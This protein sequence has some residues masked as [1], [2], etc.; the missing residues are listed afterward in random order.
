MERRITIRLLLAVI[1]FLLLFALILPATRPPKARAQR[2]SGVNSV[3][4]VTL[5]LTNTNALSSAQ[6][7][8]G[9]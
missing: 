1:G 2:I 4:S 9:K 3:R 8:L 6:P 7:G 5:I